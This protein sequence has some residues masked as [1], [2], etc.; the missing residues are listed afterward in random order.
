MV[1]GHSPALAQSNL[2]TCAENDIEGVIIEVTVKWKL[3]CSRNLNFQNL[4]GNFL[5]N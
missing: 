2:P 4:T 1:L 3:K 5:R